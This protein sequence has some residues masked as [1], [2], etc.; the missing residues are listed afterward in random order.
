MEKIIFATNNEHKLTEMRSI[1]GEGFEVV[2]L[3]EIGCHDDIPETGLT[4]EENARQKAHYVCQHYQLPCFADDT[5]LEVEA[6]GG[7][8]GVHSARYADGTD[9]DSEANMQKLLLKLQ[10]KANREARF[11]TVIAL[12]ERAGAPG[13]W[14]EHLF[15]GIV[16]GQIA[17]EKHG[18]QGF[19][20]DP[21]FQ[22]E[23]Y[24]ETFAELGSDVKNAI[25][26]RARAVRKLVEYL[27][28]K[29]Q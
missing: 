28:G 16:K 8:P 12:V 11:R 9:H 17:T 15:E 20:Y 29:A 18:T 23:G 3:K 24:T 13:A 26:H 19:G 4:L 10:G 5:G 22:P 25:S 21:L 27:H 2:S 6:L 1:L 14:T 7:E